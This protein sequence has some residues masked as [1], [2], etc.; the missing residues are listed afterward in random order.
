MARKLFTADPHFGHDAIIRYCGRNMFKSSSAMDRAIIAS[1][2]EHAGPDDELYIVGDLTMAG[3]EHIRYVGG[4]LNAI[5]AKKIL[6]LGNHDH[7]KPH[8]YVNQLGVQ[9]VHTSLVV[10]LS[11]GEEVILNHDP[12]PACTVSDPRRWLVGHLHGLFKTMDNGRVINVGVDVWD[13]KPV[14][15]EDIIVLRG[16]TG[17]PKPS[18]VYADDYHGRR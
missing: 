18:E 8:T 17:D 16:T 10:R 7:I 3:P 2:N 12:A 4:I 15:E 13:F 1:Y 6:V 14:S 11:D 5:K 9:S